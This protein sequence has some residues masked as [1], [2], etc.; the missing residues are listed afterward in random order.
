MHPYQYFT[1]IRDRQSGGTVITT[2]WHDIIYG[3]KASLV[4][5]IHGNVYYIITNQIQFYSTVKLF[6]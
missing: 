2:L 1:K 3:G 5:L 4:I 6:F